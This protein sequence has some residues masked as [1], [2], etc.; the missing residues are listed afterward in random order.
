MLKG[1][2]LKNP[3]RVFDRV[4]R[5]TVT[6]VCQQGC[7]KSQRMTKIKK[8]RCIRFSS[9]STSSSNPWSKQE[10]RQ[11][12]PLGPAKSTSL[13]C[14]VLYYC[15]VVSRALA[16]R[17][18]LRSPSIHSTISAYLCGLGYSGSTTHPHPT[19]PPNRRPNEHY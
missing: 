17:G 10:V 18:Q 3:A 19:H 7:T 1:L 16:H 4:G 8:K 5:K 11:I 2:H 13:C 6:F 9:F 15:S 14:V 12:K